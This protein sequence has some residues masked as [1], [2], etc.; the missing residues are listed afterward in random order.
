MNPSVLPAPSPAPAP[1]PSWDIPSTFLI[2]N[3]CTGSSLY[4]GGSALRH[5]HASSY[6][7]FIQIAIESFL[8]PYLNKQSRPWLG[9][10]TRALSWHCQGCGFDPW[11]E[12]VEESTDEC[13]NKWNN[14]PLSLSHFLSPPALSLKSINK[15][16]KKQ[17]KLAIPTGALFLSPRPCLIFHCN[18]YHHLTRIYA[19]WKQGLG[20][21]SLIG[22]SSRHRTVVGT[23]WTQKIFFEWMNE[24]MNAMN[25]QGSNICY[26]RHLHSGQ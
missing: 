2:P 13:I 14:K 24:W 18:T 7:S 21:F 15:F 5:S 16:L 8:A 9:I 4:W 25:K 10:S 20:L 12:H 1:W 3:L 11:S 6:I 17:F 23:W 19:F 22:V 26:L